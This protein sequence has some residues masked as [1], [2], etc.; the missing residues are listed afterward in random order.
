MA[1]QIVSDRNRPCY[2]AAAVENILG[3]IF[4]LI[5]HFFHKRPRA[6][7]TEVGDRAALL[8][9]L[10]IVMRTLCSLKED[11]NYKSVP[12]LPILIRPKDSIH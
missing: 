1:G 11:S 10:N 6:C 3:F 9:E 7:S 8:T 4:Y 2:D 12:L 5:T